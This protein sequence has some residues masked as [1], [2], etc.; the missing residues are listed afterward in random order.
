MDGR[1]PDY[2]VAIK[3]V[4]YLIE[5]HCTLIMV[6]LAPHYSCECLQCMSCVG[7]GGAG[8]DGVNAEGYRIG[9]RID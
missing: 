7:D 1:D 5:G 9:S 3:S 8:V 4:L 2:I 6:T